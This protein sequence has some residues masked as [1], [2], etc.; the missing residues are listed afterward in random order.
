[1]STP[2][3][4]SS[5]TR[6][7][8]ATLDT[9]RSGLDLRTHVSALRRF[10]KSI[11]ACI[12]L[13]L[14]LAGGASMLIQPKYETRTTFFVATETTAGSSPLQADEFAQRRINSY[15]GVINSERLANVVIDDTGL[16]LTPAD[17]SGMISASVD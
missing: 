14:L 1:M 5:R 12:L 7:P 3:A 16:Q 15:V 10:W 9:P 4:Q 17:M 13:G 11:I 6:A 2:Q 8:G